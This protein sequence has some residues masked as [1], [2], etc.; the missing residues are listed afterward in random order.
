MPSSGNTASITLADPGGTHHVSSFNTCVPYLFITEPSWTLSIPDMKW[1][2]T[3]S[4][5]PALTTYHLVSSP[6][7]TWN[8]SALGF[9]SI[10]AKEPTAGTYL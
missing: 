9:K 8:T 5:G 6:G 3:P 7:W 10:V 2:A 4:F 1:N